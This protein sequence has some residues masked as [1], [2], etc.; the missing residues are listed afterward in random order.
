A[1]FSNGVA[2]GEYYLENLL[3]TFAYMNADVVSMNEDK[4]KYVDQ[5]NYVENASMISS[6]KFYSINENHNE[7][8]LFNIPQTEMEK[9]DNNTKET[10]LKDN[11]RLS[12]IIPVRDEDI[13]YLESKTLYSLRGL[14]INIRVV[15]YNNVSPKNETLLE[16]IARKYKNVDCFLEDTSSNVNRAVNS[17]I[18]SIQSEF[19]FILSPGNQVSR[20]NIKVFLKDLENVNEDIVLC[21][22][23][24]LIASRKE[25]NSFELESGI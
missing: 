10:L 6:E 22:I 8:K 20:S 18:S 9:T 3:A 1:K 17:S 24:D 11:S 5:S 13:Y 2:Y 23:N 7:V 19:F 12:V 25:S 14:N 15:P 21:E 16:R 4:Y